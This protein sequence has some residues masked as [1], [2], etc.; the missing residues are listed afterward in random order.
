MPYGAGRRAR[1]AARRARA[2]KSSGCSRIRSATACRTSSATGTGWYGE[3]F[4]HTPA[5]QPA[6]PQ[7]TS[8]LP[9]S[10]A[11]ARPTSSASRR[12]SAA[13]WSRC[14]LAQQRAVDRDHPRRA[15]G[16]QRTAHVVDDQAALRL[17]DDL[18]DRLRGGLR[19]VGVAAD[20][21]EVLEPREQGG[22]QR[23]DQHLD[24]DEPQAARALRSSPVRRPVVSR[25]CHQSRARCGS[26]TGNSAHH[27]RQH[28]RGE[29]HV[30][31]HRDEDHLEQSP[32]R[33]SPG[34][35]APARSARRPRCRRTTT[36]RRWRPTVARAVGWASLTHPPG[37]VADD[38][39]RQ[40]PAPG[41][42]VGRRCEVERRGRRRSPST[43]ANSG[44]RTS[45]AATT[46]SR[47]RLG[48]TPSHAKCGKTD[49][50][51]T[52]AQRRARARPRRARRLMASHRSSRRPRSRRGRSGCR[53]ARRRRPGRASRSRRTAR[54]R[55]AWTSRAG[56]CR[57]RDPADRDAGDV[58][59]TVLAAPGDDGVVLGGDRGVV[60]ELEVEAAVA[61]RARRGRAGSRPPCCARAGRRRPSP[62]RRSAAPSRWCGSA[63]STRPT[64]PSLLSTVMSGSMPGVGAGVD[65]HGAR[66]RL[67]RTQ[68][69]DPGGDQRVAGSAAAAV[70][71]SSSASRLRSSPEVASC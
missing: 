61:G 20:D 22:E 2:G 42:V 62:G 33:R 69:D 71:P 36:R 23:E 12:S 5:S 18:A 40:R 59:R 65:G 38:D 46:T 57:P 41:D 67:R 21:L 51:R 43:A 55:P 8:S 47:Q 31:E 63:R 7:V 50:C 15:V 45:A 48:T 52:T 19:L 1:S 28:E 39:Q 60:D 11:S 35:R 32:T 56:C 66:E 49:T 25:A 24:H 3:P 26:S 13:C 17:H 70:S 14:H 29:Q 64:R 16:D 58:R 4:Q 54:S 30:P 53:T 9:G 27:R 68:R 6:S 34:R 37:E 10:S 44:P